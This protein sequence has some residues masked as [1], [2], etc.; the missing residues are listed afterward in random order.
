MNLSDFM[1]DI[2]VPTVT[3]ITG[4][5][6][7]VL[8]AKIATVDEEIKLRDQDLKEKISQIDLLIAKSKEDREERESSQD[9]NLRIYDIVTESLEKKDPEKQ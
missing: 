3:A 8:N 1:R 6:I 9:F 4:V 7:F 2:A 5:M